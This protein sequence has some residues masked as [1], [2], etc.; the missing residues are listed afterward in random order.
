MFT[1]RIMMTAT[2]QVPEKPE[3]ASEAGADAGGSS[4][5]TVFLHIITVIGSDVSPHLPIA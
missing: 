2:S 5:S 1:G 3:P 4:I